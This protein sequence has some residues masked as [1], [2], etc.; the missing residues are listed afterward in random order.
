MTFL[1]CALA[2]SF[3]RDRVAQAMASPKPWKKV[4]G[5]LA[6]NVAAPFENFAPCSSC[7]QAS[8]HRPVQFI[9]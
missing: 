3:L 1:P 5:I 7:L 8:E 4:F 6:S 2:H 9:K